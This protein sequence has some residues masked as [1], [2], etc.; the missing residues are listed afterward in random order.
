MNTNEEYYEEWEKAIA[1]L[2]TK[3]KELTE[4][5]EEN[6]SSE[7]EILTTFNFKG[8]YGKDNDR[9]RKL[10][11]KQELADILKKRHDLEQR[12]DHLKR[13]IDFISNIVQR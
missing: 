11:V 2:E 5:I 9:I 6:Y 13:R 4:V 7:L 1:E 8:K 12:I 3:S 10:H